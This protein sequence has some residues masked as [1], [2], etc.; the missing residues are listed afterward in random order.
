MWVKS[1]NLMCTYAYWPISHEIFWAITALTDTISKNMRTWTI[2]CKKR[3]A[4][5]WQFFPYS[6]S[7][8]LKRKSEKFGK[9]FLGPRPAGNVRNIFGNLW[10]C[11]S[12]EIFDVFSYSGVIF[13]NS[14]TP[15]LKVS[16]L[17]YRNSC[18]IEISKY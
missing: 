14:G 8:S 10:A 13:K 6:I 11:S 5:K 3:N 7:L 15:D 18:H 17:W 12:L 4:R 9:I 1:I 16:C 2:K